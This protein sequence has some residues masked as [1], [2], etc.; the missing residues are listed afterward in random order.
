MMIIA[1]LYIQKYYKISVQRNCFN[2][3]NIK[4]DITFIKNAKVSNKNG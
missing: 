1:H 3:F 2:N 4:T